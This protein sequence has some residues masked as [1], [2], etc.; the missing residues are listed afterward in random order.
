VGVQPKRRARR[1]SWQEHVIAKGR[2]L[3]NQRRL[4]SARDSL[5]DAEVKQ[6]IEA[7]VE[8]HLNAAHQA[9][10]ETP[11]GG[12]RRRRPLDRLVNTWTGAQV[13]AAFLNLHAAEVVLANLYTEEEVQ[14]RVPDMLAR[15]RACVPPPTS[16]GSTR[17]PSSA[18]TTAPA[19]TAWAASSGTGR[20]G[21]PPPEPWSGG[22]PSSATRCRSATTPPT[23]ST[24]GSAA[25]GTC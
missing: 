25:S 13:E 2:F 24:P 12:P 1:A 15:L 19:G 23:S 11:D 10:G 3:E 16:A 22:G 20:A 9:A 17:R 5:N 6:L 8:K 7:A 18:A 4:L 14:A 21:R